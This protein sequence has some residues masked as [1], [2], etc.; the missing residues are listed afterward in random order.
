MYKP[1]LNVGHKKGKKMKRIQWKCEAIGDMAEDAVPLMPGERKVEYCP[2]TSEERRDA[3]KF[4]AQS[5]LLMTS[6]LVIVIV[7]WR[8][9]VIPHDAQLM[10]TFGSQPLR[11]EH[12]STSGDQ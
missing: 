5:F 8:V 1:W 10:K 2:L 9:Y 11:L 3:F 4:L 6:F 12:P 7:W